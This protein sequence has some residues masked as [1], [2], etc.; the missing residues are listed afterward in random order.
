[1]PVEADDE[2]TARRHPEL[3]R[4]DGTWRDLHRVPTARGTRCVALRGDGC[5][6]AFRCAIYADRPT[7]CRELEAGSWNCWFAR[8]RVGLWPPTPSR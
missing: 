8:S 2:H 4:M 1:M 3:I 7:A 6:E 5:G